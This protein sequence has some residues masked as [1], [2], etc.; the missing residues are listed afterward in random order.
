[1]FPTRYFANRYFAP[2]YFPKRGAAPPVVT[3]FAFQYPGDGLSWAGFGDGYFPEPAPGTPHRYKGAGGLGPVKV[4]T[5]KSR[6][7][8]V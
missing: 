1:M 3:G 5:R 7:I 8:D 2:R 6:K 4:V